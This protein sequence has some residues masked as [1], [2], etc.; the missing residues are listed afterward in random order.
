[1]FFFAGENSIN[2]N[3]NIKGIE[4]LFILYNVINL[5][6]IIIQHTL[7]EFY[8]ADFQFLVNKPMQIFYFLG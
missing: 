8:L 2:F 6:H 4:S 3:I 1:M 7:E 5:Q